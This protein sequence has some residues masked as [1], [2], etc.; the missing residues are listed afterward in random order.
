MDVSASGRELAK[1]GIA[2][3]LDNARDWKSLAMIELQNIHRERSCRGEPDFT[4]EMLKFPVVRA[5]GNPHSPNVWGGLAQK[6]VK[7]GL[8]KETGVTTAK[9]GSRRAS[10]VRTYRWVIL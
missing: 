8:I 5:C 2:Q 3:V 10:L 1:A 4:F 6:M 9:S 7:L